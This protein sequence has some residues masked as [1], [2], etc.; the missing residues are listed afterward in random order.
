MKIYSAYSDGRLRLNLEGELDHHEAKSSLRTID[1]IIDDL[2]PR[3]CIIDLSN[4]SFMDS[5]GIAVIMRVHKR[6]NDMC[7]KAWVENPNGQPLRVLDASG[8]DRVIR[9]YS[10]TE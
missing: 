7:G 10:K 5:S 1:R 9:V 3:D 2:L 8:I 4:L 6:M